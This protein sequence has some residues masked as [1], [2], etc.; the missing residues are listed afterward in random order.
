MSCMVSGAGIARLRADR[1]S[2]ALYSGGLARLTDP[3]ELFADPAELF[4]DPAELFAD[5]AELFADP[6]ELSG[7]GELPF[8]PPFFLVSIF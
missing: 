6:A 5:P 3:A 1:S 4:A 8:F 2:A 7:A